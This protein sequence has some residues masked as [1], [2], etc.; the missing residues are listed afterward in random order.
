MQ[1]LDLRNAGKKGPILNVFLN[2]TGEVT[3]SCSLQSS[4]NG[5][6]CFWSTSFSFQPG[7]QDAK[8][9]MLKD[10][11]LVCLLHLGILKPKIDCK[12]SPL[13]TQVASHMVEQLL[14]SGTCCRPMG[15]S[16]E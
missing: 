6:P 12:C 7:H 16:Y 9:L 15:K 13:G 10:L 3:T 8:D 2:F 4:Q 11:L 1:L 5:G 14:L